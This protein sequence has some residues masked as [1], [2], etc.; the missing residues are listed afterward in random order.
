M[1]IV[2]L[3]GGFG[4]RL[5]SVVRDVPKPMAD[6]AGTPFLELLLR[7]LSFLDPERFVLCVSYKKD[8]IKDYFKD[9]FLGIPVVYSEENEPLGTGG[10][11]KQAFDLFNLNDALVLNGDSYIQANYARFLEQNKNEKLAVMLKRVDDANRYG[12]VEIENSRIV[13]FKEKNTTIS[14]PGLINAGIYKVT[15]DLFT[16]SLPNKF[17]FEQDILEPMIPQLKPRFM[18]ADDYFIDIGIPTSYAQ[19]QKELKSVIYGNATNRALF[20]DRDGVIS[21]DIGYLHKIQDCQFMPGIFD[22][23]RQYKNN[24][25]KLIIV[26]NQAGI[27]KGKFSEQDYK[28]LT[29]FIHSQFKKQYCEI[30]AEYYCPYHIDGLPP[31]NRNSFYRKPN[32]GMIL[33]AAKDYNINLPESALIGDNETDILAAKS[34]GVGNT[35]RIINEQNMRGTKTTVADNI[36]K[37]IQKQKIIHK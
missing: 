14:Q 16:R 35:I 19:A 31:Y 13:D 28:L 22:F 17:S 21:E 36:I 1:N 30:T 2:I 29:D 37:I 24:G 23:C 8:I 26:T 9:S 7:E 3:A 10:A 32:P 20:L 12:R 33:R 34:A 15:K 18:L 11:I 27:A 5:Q 4:T 25:Y 6:I